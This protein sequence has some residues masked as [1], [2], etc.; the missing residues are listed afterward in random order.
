MDSA[1]LIACLCADWCTTC[2][3]YG[4]TFAE[5]ARAH[6]Q[7]RFVW[8]DIEEHSDAL[9]DGALDIDNFPTLMLL[10]GTTPLFFGTLLPHAGTLA[11]LVSAAQAGAL[12][13]TPADPALALAVHALAQQQPA[14]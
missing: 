7:A 10:R 3:A 2:Q 12:A 11:R 8:I 4:A 9:G 5:V 13:H 1:L 14:R 6:P